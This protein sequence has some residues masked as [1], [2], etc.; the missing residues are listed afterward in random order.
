M[1]KALISI[2]LSGPFLISCDGALGGGGGTA[3]PDPPGLTAVEEGRERRAR[4]K[5]QASQREDQGEGEDLVADPVVDPADAVTGEATG[6]GGA[7]APAGEDTGGQAG[8][9][10]EVANAPAP[11]ASGGSS[12]GGRGGR[13]GRG[14]GGE[15]TFE[16]SVVDAG[17]GE[18]LATVKGRVTY[19]GI[20]PERKPIVAATSKPECCEN[21]EPIPLEEGI[22]V[23]DGG[24]RDV[25]VRVRKVPSGVTIPDP[26]AEPYVMDQV[27]CAYVPHV[28]AIQAGRKVLARNSDGA[29]HNVRVSAVSNPSLNATMQQGAPDL[30]LEVPKP[31]FVK[32]GCDIHPW[33][34]ADLHV[35]EHPWFDVSAGD[36]SFSITDLP[37]GT[38][39]FE[40]LHPK[41]GKARSEPVTLAGGA[42]LRLDLAFAGR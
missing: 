6:D 5:E 12:R 7:D 29:P 10:S 21:G 20:A 25:L 39:E 14:R 32:L 30:V 42:V 9:G 27:G 17:A 24:L 22:V 13:G 40:A 15:G 37:P 2:V 11:D 8:G 3:D 28:G 34:A 35:H 1:N 36:G 31:E 26:P 18:G 16:A 19:D 4:L 33:M 38:W 41:L 23:E